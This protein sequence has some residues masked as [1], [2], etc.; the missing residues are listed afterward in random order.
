MGTA[1]WELRLVE[2]RF[3]PVVAL[4]LNSTFGIMQYLSMATSSYGDIFKLK[5]DQLR[6]VLVPNPQHLDV[7]AW[8]RFYATVAA[9]P[10]LVY[11]QEF[12]RAA[13]GVGV[14][15]AIDRFVASQLGLELP[16]K[17]IYELLAV[18]PV[19]TKNRL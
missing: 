14:R 9:E 6:G 13:E 4:W 16:G 11:G 8:E 7:A 3:K 10:L 2:D 19:V 15:L 5:K 12:R 1:F 18:D 17:T